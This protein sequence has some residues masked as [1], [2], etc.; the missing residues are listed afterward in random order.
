MEAKDNNL[1]NIPKENP[2]SVPNGYFE[3]LTAHIMEQIPKEEQQTVEIKVTMWDKVRPILY[4][5]AMFAGLGFFFKAI[6]FF[7]NSDRLPNQTDTLLVNSN[8]PSD[9]TMEKEYESEE[10]EYLQYLEDQYTEALIQN[11]LNA[12]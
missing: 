6:A 3:G 10:N 4:L 7:D 9:I 12:E 1:K 11:E 2:F 5:A 8:V